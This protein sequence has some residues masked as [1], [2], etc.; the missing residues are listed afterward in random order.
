MIGEKLQ[1]MSHADESR[2]LAMPIIKCKHGITLSC[3]YE[4]HL[5]S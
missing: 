5:S 4:T 3:K 1:K 2:Q